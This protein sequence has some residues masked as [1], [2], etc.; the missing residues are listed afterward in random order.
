MLRIARKEDM[1][2]LRAVGVRIAAVLLALLA[3]GLLI[4]AMGYDP[5]EVVRVMWSGMRTLKA[6]ASMIRIAIPLAMAALAVSIAFTMKFWNIGAEGQILMGAFA[7][8]AISSVLPEGTPGA[9][10]ILLMALAGLAGGALWALP[11]ALFRAAFRTNETPLTLMFNYIAIRWVEYLRCQLWK[12]PAAMGFPQ[13]A[14]IPESAHLP[15]LL[16]VHIGWIL[17]LVLAF[18]Q[19]VFLRRTKKGFEVRVVGESEKTARYAGMTVGRVLLF[20]V[21]L[22]GALAGLTGMVKLNGTAFVLAERL[23]GGDGFTA[24]I[25]AWLSN[26]SAP[27]ILVVAFLFAA[28]KQGAGWME[29]LAGIPSA[30]ADTVQGLILFFALGSE[31]FIRYRIILESRHRTER[32]EA[33]P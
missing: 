12:D 32:K 6:L 28:M 3:S 13:I 5:R 8:T 16:G 15:Q 31:F 11:P 30:L 17:V 26:L 21:L 27:V 25:I 2:G 24:I 23:A 9:L 20:G 22:S 10:R 14:P 29:G 19:W 4:L 33:H 7:A 1:T 18:L